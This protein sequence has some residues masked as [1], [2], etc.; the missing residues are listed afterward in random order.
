MI[1]AS[2]EY[3]AYEAQLIGAT[4][5]VRV[6]FLPYVWPNGVNAD[7]EF[8]HCAYVAPDRI[9]ADYEGFTGGGWFSE[10]LTAANLQVPSSPAVVSF[11]WNSPGFDMIVYWRAASTSDL[12]ATAPWNLVADGD[13][14]QIE[15]F[16]Q[17]KMTLDGYRAWAVD[18][19]GDA[20]DWTAYAVDVSGV[21]AEQGYAAET[22][23]PGDPLTYIEALRL[24]GE[25]TVVRDI[26]QA[27]TV[28]MEAPKAFDDLVAGSMSG[29]LL[30]NRQGSGAVTVL[31]PDEIDYTWTPAP[32]FSPDK[33]SFFLAGQ[34]WYNFKVRIDLG[35]NQ[36]GWFQDKWLTDTW[37]KDE[38]TDFLTL[39]L[40]RL[41][42][43]GP[44]NR[45]VDASGVEQA[46]TVEIYAADFI[47]DCLQTRIC[48]P[49]ADGTPA[50]LTFGEF[51][52]KA[53]AVAGWSP[54]P[55]LRSAYFEQPN[56]HEL[57]HVVTSGDGAVSLIEPG[58][59]GARAIRFQ[60]IGASQ[61]A[62]ASFTLPYPGEIFITGTLRFSVIP[63]TL[64]L[65]NL[66][67]LQILDSTGILD[68]S[69]WLDTSG[70]ICFWGNY[71]KFN[72]KA[73]EGVPLAFGMWLLPANPGYVKVWI[74][75][76]EIIT[77]TGD[78][79]GTHPL[80]VRFGAMTMGVAETWTVDFED[81]EVRSKYYANAYKVDGGPFTD[82][83]AVYLDNVAQPDTQSVT[84]NSTVYTQTLTRYPQ[85]GM[86]DFASDD[87]QF[88]LSGEVMVRVIEHAGGRHALAVIENLVGA[89]GLTDY[90][91]APALAAA[92]AVCPDD[93]INARFEGG[94]K[95]GQFGLKDYASLGITVGDCLKEICSR[96]LYWIFM[97]AGQIKIIPYTG[98]ALTD[99]VLALTA[100]NL[101]SV[102]PIIDLESIN[103]FVTAIY[104]WYS[105]NPSLFY[106]A[107]TPTD[108]G[109][110]KGLD[111]SWDGPVACENRDVVKA[112]ADLFLQWLSA[113]ERVEPVTLSLAG[114]R[115]E[116]MDVVSLRDVLLNDTAQNYFVSRKDVGL[117]PGSRLT[118]LQLMRF[119]GE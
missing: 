118:T 69:L 109:Q 12:L 19:V 104:G 96:M 108:G 10:V 63:G 20:D 110:G 51:L 47:M 103:D 22:Q 81:L 83:G 2:A 111:Y 30:S 24:L 11:D 116:L 106:V 92:Y 40:G 41:K 99:P 59:A 107:G 115:L 84:N 28:T 75:G 6:T 62:Y 44:A 80:E 57:D 27:G 42:K 77:Y 76:N 91:N 34:D 55:P 31:G 97:D 89:A 21:E 48:L 114:A 54:D 45:A 66:D 29:L 3:Q 65:G 61:V 82:I 94:G 39:F 79:S 53:D 43:W 46:N 38:F 74:N 35:W 23:V 5:A 105:R 37:F 98:G 58:I 56:Y 88:K 50:P 117:D 36:G 90:I 49:A 25:F 17:F 102:S 1:P 18:E 52:C 32:F 85:Y 4:P 7:G 112:K 68:A 100:S 8:V 16:Y 67:F 73:Y 64:A 13:T 60:T 72:I 70:N 93:F 71:S 113:Q 26:E 78:F 87:P 119:L 33:S 14:I 101:Y 15:A 86:V 9:Q 95:V